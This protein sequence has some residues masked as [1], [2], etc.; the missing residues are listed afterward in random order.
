MIEALQ[1]TKRYED[2]TLGLDGFDLD[3]EAG[4]IYAL[5]GANGAGKSTAINLFLG[6]IE[7][8]SGSARV[9]GIDVAKDPLK[10]KRHVGYLSENV[11]MYPNFTARQNL[12]FFARLG[13]RR[14]SREESRNALSAVGLAEAAHD[15][16]VRAFSKGMRQKL[17]IAVA[18]ISEP[19]ALIL[20]EPMSGLDP[21]SAAEF[22]A[23]LRR[24]REAGKAI[25]LS[26][27]DIFRAKH[28]ADRVGIMRSGRKVVELAG[29]ELAGVDLETTYRRYMEEPA[30][31][32]S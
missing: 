13:R 18:T 7:P 12:E 25:L 8:T 19:G 4:E 14:L 15:Q 21:T 22:V 28:L 29:A 1:L 17:G 10:A 3:V 32:R 24:L 11:T 31:H 23:Y 16:R 9:H 6:F 5:L 26:T 27:H 20:D 30:E 2:G